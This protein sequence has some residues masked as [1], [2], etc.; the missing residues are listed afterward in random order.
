MLSFIVSLAWTLCVYL[1][2]HTRILTRFLPKNAFQQ[3]R[4]AK[5]KALDQEMTDALARSM[6]VQPSPPTTPTSPA[7]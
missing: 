7:K 3:V 4:A 1:A 5:I 2:G 6:Q